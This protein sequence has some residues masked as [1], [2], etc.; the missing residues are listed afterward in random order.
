LAA[1][2]TNARGTGDR[3]L[4]AISHPI[5]IE[6]LRVLASRSAS[7]KEIAAECGEPISD[8]SYHVRYLRREGYVEMVDT[9]AR[10]GAIE[11]YYRTTRSSDSATESL[12]GLIGE[13]VRALNSSTVD[14]RA[15]RQLS[16]TTMELD[17][18]GWAELVE[19]QRRWRAELEQVEAAAAE[20]L[21]RDGGPGKTVLAATLGFETPR[22]R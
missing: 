14:A 7:P 9:E 11:H 21:A 16:W 20:R 6:A 12:R 10:R 4:R 5:R 1:G 3:L 15:D 2:K 19:R 18:Q 8:V 22:A 13:A 17:E